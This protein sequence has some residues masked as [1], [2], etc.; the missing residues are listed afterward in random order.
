MTET[1]PIARA[2]VYNEDKILVLQNAEDDENPDARGTWEHPGGRV[3]DHDDH[4]KAAVQREVR[5]ETGIDIEI[6]EKLPRIAVEECGMV[7]DCQLYLARSSSRNVTLSEEHRD[8]RWI[9]PEEFKD[10]DWLNVAGYTIPVL[11]RIQDRIGERD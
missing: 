8:Y 9:K 4:E 11:E 10:M 1:V 7:A 5:E 6:E 3:E 2:I